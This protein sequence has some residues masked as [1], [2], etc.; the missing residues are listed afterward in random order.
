MRK[1]HNDHARKTA[2]YRRSALVNDIAAARRDKHLS[3]YVKLHGHAETVCF[4]DSGSSG[5]TL[6][7]PALNDLASRIK[8]GEIG[9][10]LVTNISRIAR[11]FRLYAE[12]SAI[13]GEHG[14]KLIAPQGG[15]RR[16]HGPN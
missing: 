14:A 7:R 9:T 4:R 16:K 3:E 1:T 2:I 13:L 5:N 12:W 6:D 11:N 8:A 10:V 15:A